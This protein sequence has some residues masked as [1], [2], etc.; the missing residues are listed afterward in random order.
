MDLSPLSLL[1]FLLALWYPSTGGKGVVRVQRAML[2]VC[3]PR[4][5]ELTT[6]SVVI[7]V[8]MVLINLTLFK[9]DSTLLPYVIDVLLLISGIVLLTRYMAESILCVRKHGIMHTCMQKTVM[10]CS[11]VPF[12]ASAILI[13]VSCPIL[14][15]LYTF[16]P[17]RQYAIKNCGSGD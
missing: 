17:G 6:I 4:V 2:P 12:A 11:V 16:L 13:H 8:K 15:S 10:L 7:C 3:A 1:P 9:Q 14:S 5:L